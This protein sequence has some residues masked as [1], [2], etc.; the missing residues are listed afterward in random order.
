M[1]TR[2]L[3]VR[4][5]GLRQYE[6]TYDAMRAFTEARCPTTHDE[7]WLTEHPPVFTQGLAGKPEHVLESG[8]IPIV[9]TDRG[10]QVTYHGPGQLVV[11]CL[12]D[13]R[14]AG[15]SIRALVTLLEQT[16][17]DLLT[18][19]G[20]D[21]FARSDAPGVYVG[22]AKI[23][24]LG[25][26]VRRGYTYHG[27]SLNVATDLRPFS[28][29]NPCGYR[30]LAM[31]RITDLLSPSDP[32]SLALATVG[33]HFAKR[34]AKAAN[35]RIDDTIAHPLNELWPEKQVSGD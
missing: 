27:L 11:Y 33:K 5:L 8:N 19:Y 25:L 26:R 9:R 20:I 29:I 2:T 6:A 31:T 32:R 30:D 28:Q 23:A 21:S 18:D 10:G 1:G 4:Q 34:M 14:R 7:L 12:L 15:L 3:N 17:I 24:S 35:Y 22:A 13:I 16:T